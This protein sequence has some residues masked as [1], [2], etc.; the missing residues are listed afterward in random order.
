M[1]DEQLI[2][3]TDYG[4]HLERTWEMTDILG[5]MGSIVSVR[6]CSC[7]CTD[8]CNKATNAEEIAFPGY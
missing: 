7:P 1:M 6:G 4:T 3:A 8:A 5:T 2:E